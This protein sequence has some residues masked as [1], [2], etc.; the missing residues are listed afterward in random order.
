MQS[1]SELF[2][3][4]Y[5]VVHIEHNSMVW[6]FS[7]VNLLGGAAFLRFSCFAMA[8]GVVSGLA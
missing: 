3:F 5:V 4:L 6:V 7:I 2:V 8:L 1:A